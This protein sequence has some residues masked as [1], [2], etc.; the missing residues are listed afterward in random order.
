MNN[1]VIEGDFMKGTLISLSFSGRVILGNWKRLDITNLIDKAELI[2]TENKISIMSVAG[3]GILGALIFGPVGVLAGA[4]LGGRRKQYGIICYLKDG[5][6]F[7]AVVDD[8]LLRRITM[9]SSYN[10]S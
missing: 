4:I 10:K 6:K 3:W 9:L 2:T 1:Q 7:M 5:R 8:E